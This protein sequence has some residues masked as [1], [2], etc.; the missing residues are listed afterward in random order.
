[1]PIRPENRHRYPANWRELSLQIRRDRAG[2]VCEAPGC[3]AQQG[4]PHPVTGSLVVLTVAHVDQQPE[5]NAPTNL[6]AWCQRCHLNHDRPH[7]V[8]QAKRTRRA[9]LA[10]LELPV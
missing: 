7:N 6:A 5:N 9:Q 8:R 3:G 10:T 4:K 2:W 1:M